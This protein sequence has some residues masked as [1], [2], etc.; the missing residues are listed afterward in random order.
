[1][2]NRRLRR[3]HLIGAVKV[4]LSGAGTWIDA[5]LMNINRGGIGLYS[6]ERIKKGQKVDIRIS[7]LEGTKMRDV[8]QIPGKV[9]WVQPIGTHVAMGVMFEAS[10]TKKT[11]P[12]LNGCLAYAAGTTDK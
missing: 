9:R 5:T 11:F 12:I 10:V 7:Y 1:M 4:K 3:R 8:E 6:T 2:E